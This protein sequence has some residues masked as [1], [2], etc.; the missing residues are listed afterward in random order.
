MKIVRFT[1][2]IGNYDTTKPNLLHL[3]E[4]VFRNNARNAR[5]VKLLAH[6]YIDCDISVY[7]DAN[8]QLAELTDQRIVELMEGCDMIIMTHKSKSVYD[9][10]TAAM[11]RVNN[12]MELDRLKQQSAHY[13]KIGF[14]ESIKVAGYQPLI[15]RHTQKVNSFFE[16]WFAETCRYSYRDQVSFP[17]VLSRHNIITKEFDLSLLAKKLYAHGGK[18]FPVIQ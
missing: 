6:K 16:D 14:P 9:E 10:A 17:V 1:T 2:N 18:T 4:S 8:M 13:K 5:A 11:T 15:R 12:D 7:V 3:T